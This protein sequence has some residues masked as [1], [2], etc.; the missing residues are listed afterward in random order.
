[1]EVLYPEK[2][3]ARYNSL[4]SNYQKF[5][6]KVGYSKQNPKNDWASSP[7]RENWKVLEGLEQHAHR[8]RE[9][10]RLILNQLTQQ[11][12]QRVFKA[13]WPYTMV[14]SFVLHQTSLVLHC[15]IPLQSISLRYHQLLDP[16]NELTK[17]QINLWD[18]YKNADR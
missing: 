18:N 13:T 16:F 7:E 17:S 5:L 2:P 9:W 12:F 4:K 3:K 6:N 14:F 11:I 1:M 15:I 8:L 10:Q